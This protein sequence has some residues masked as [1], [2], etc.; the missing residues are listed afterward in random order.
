M[1]RRDGSHV[2]AQLAG[3]IRDLRRRLRRHLGRATGEIDKRILGL[4]RLNNKTL[5][6]N[7]MDGRWKRTKLETI[8]EYEIPAGDVPDLQD[9]T[10]DRRM[11]I[12]PRKLILHQIYQTDQVRSAYV[13][14]QQVRRDGELSGNKSVSCHAKA[15][16]R[17]GFWATTAAP[18]WLNNL[19]TAEG[20]R[21]HQ[22]P[23]QY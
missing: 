11:M 21:W 3:R 17:P 23:G 19:L 2:L 10:T 6:R 13:E 7:D 15:E 1:S 16:R 14:G 22:H 9:G 20:L 18:P 8:R 12:R 4:V 5:G